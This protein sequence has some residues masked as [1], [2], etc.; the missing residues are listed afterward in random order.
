MANHKHIQWLLKG[1]EAWNERRRNENFTPDLEDRDIPEEFG[2]GGAQ[3]VYH[4][5]LDGV[6]LSGIDLSGAKLQK[7]ILNNVNLSNANLRF[8][9]LKECDLGGAILEDADL[10]F[11]DLRDCQCG[12]VAQLRGAKMMG[13]DRNA[14]DFSNTTM[15]GADFSQADLRDAILA[16]RKLACTDLRHADLVGTNLFRAQ[17]WTATLFSEENS[18]EGT[19]LGVNDDETVD[20]VHSLLTK[21]FTITGNRFRRVLYFRGEAKTFPELRPSLTRMKNGTFVHNLEAEAKMI[22][23]L[24]SRRPEEFD[25]LNSA[26]AQLVIA[27]HHG[28][29]TRLLDITRNPLVGLFHA[30]Q[31]RKE[32]SDEECGR[33][34][35]FAVPECLI[36]PFNSNAISVIANFAKLSCKEQK[37]L[38]GKR[39]EDP[40]ADV[41]PGGPEWAGYYRSAMD[42]LYHFIRQ[43]KPYFQEKIDPRD[44]FRVFIVEPQ[45]S[46]E[47][48]RAQSGAFLISAFH[49]QF[50]CSEILKQNPGIPVY[51]HCNLKVPDTKKRCILDELRLLNITRETLFPGLDEAAKAVT[52]THSR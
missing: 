5:K 49:E 17:P 40:P 22:V 19:P 14:D 43:E 39:K 45:Q 27:Q 9:D 46:F 51:D 11:A 33:L 13:G 36:K 29:P 4:G 26:L 16:N 7:A 48:I 25:N 37:Q 30:C 24:M 35:V 21:C 50:E 23:D 8:A 44:F 31:E 6:N 12:N 41:N 38:L 18:G 32:G 20:S 47:R 10:D 3:Q 52:Q 34:H 42:R 1:V 15:C 2:K 28:L